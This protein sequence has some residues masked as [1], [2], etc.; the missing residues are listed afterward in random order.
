MTFGEALEALV[1]GKK[2]ARRGWNGKRMWLA[3]QTDMLSDDWEIV[4]ERQVENVNEQGGD[5][6][7][8]DDEN[9]A[10]ALGKTIGTMLAPL[11]VLG[12]GQ[13]KLPDIHVNVWS[14]GSR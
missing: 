4:G 8:E 3:S 12:A 5:D 1:A 9:K 6:G 2:V 7:P 13:G 14:F 10:E 11:A